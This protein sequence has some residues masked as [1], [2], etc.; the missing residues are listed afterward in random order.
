MPGLAGL[1]SLI[2]LLCGKLKVYGNLVL[3]AY[4]LAIQNAGRPV[5]T[6]RN[7]PQGFLIESA[8]QSPDQA[9]IC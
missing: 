8:A 6:L 5:G 9:N 3:N 4:R 2:L 1:R 7:H